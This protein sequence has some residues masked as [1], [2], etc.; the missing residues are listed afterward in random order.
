M[1]VQ[2]VVCC[3]GGIRCNSGLEALEAGFSFMYEF[4]EGCC[5]GLDS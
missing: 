1:L 4:S 3:W 2:V 5:G